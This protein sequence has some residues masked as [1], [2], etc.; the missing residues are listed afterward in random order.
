VQ[1]FRDSTVLVQIVN[2][3][4]RPFA[5]SVK[6]YCDQRFDKEKVITDARA[7]LEAR[8]AFRNMQLGEAVTASAIIALLQVI[9][10]VLGVDLDYLHFSSQPA[11][12]ETRL[13]ARAGH[14]DRD[15]AI[16][17]A[18]LL[19]LDTAALSLTAITTPA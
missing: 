3:V 19:T 17:A 2:H 4:P 18:E 10:G 6:L 14:V 13:A 1:S 5:V 16:F 11:T 15:G 12:R 8:Y 7:A 9:P